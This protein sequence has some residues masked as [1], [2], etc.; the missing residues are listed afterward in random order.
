M[1]RI[2]IIGM[3]YVCLVTGAA[4]AE[5]GHRVVAVDVVRKKVSMVNEGRSPIHE[6]GLAGLLERHVPERLRATTDLAEAMDGAEFV[7]I[8]VG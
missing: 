8:A 1:A 4:F 5:R 6:D 7:F 2:A 3:G